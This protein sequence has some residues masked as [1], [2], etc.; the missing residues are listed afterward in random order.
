ML[1]RS[2][3]PQYSEGLQWLSIM[4]PVCV[5]NSRMEILSFTALK[6]LIKEAVLMKINLIAAGFAAMLA[7]ACG[8]FEMEHRVLILMIVFVTTG[9]SIV[10][11]L[12]VSGT[13]IQ[14]NTASVATTVV[15]RCA[16]LVS[17][18]VC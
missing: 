9:R 12:Y 17:C 14:A 2:W 18:D 11:E 13:V 8:L 16:V 1:F 3:F 6:V 15:F 5:Y 7:G 4:L 10:S